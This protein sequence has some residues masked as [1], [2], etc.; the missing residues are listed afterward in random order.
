MQ[1]RTLGTAGS[2]MTVSLSI[3]GCTD[4]KNQFDEKRQDWLDKRFKLGRLQRLGGIYAEL[5]Q[6]ALSTK[7]LGIRSQK[8]DNDIH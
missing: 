7:P 4:S 3:K 1:F 2:A 5:E 8:V 6:E